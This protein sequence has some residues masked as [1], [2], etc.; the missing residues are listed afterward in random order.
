MLEREY[1]LEDIRKGLAVLQNYVQP[2]GKLN[3]TDTN[4][5]AEH[6]VAGLLN[7]I[8]GWS[9]V[10]TNQE[11]ANYPCIDLIDEGRGLGVQVT[12]ERGSAKLTETLEC[13]KKHGL[14][15]T[16]R[17]LIVFSLIAKQDRYT[18]N[19]GCPGIA[20]DW[21]KDVLDF[22][23]AIHAAIGIADLRQLHQVHLHVVDAMPS[24]FP[25][26]HAHIPPVHVPVTDRAIAWLAFSSRA[27][28]L[29]GRE[30][31][32]SRLLEFLNSPRRFSW[33][34][35]TGT[36]GSG[37]SRLALEL[38]RQA[39]PEWRAGF[40]SRTEKDFKWSQFSPSQKTLIV[41]DYVA[42]RAADVGEAVLALCRASSSFTK[43]VR[44]L[45]VE[46]DKSSWWTTFSREASLSESA[47]IA[48]CMHGEPLGLPRL[49]PKAILELAEDVVRAR[50]GKWN[51]VLAREFLLRFNHFDPYGRP[52]FAMIVADYL[53]AVESDAASPDLL[54][55]VL[56]R[57]AGRWRNLIQ[58]PDRLQR[59]ENLLFLATL[60]SGLLPK[61]NGFD[62]LAA[63]DAAGLLP[64]AELLDESLYND[65]AGAAGGSGSL[66]GL[67]PD[68]LGERFVLERVS[69]KGIAGLNAR[70]LLLAAWSFQPRDVGVVAARSAFDFHGHQELYKLF[71]LPVDSSESRT[72]WAEM[73]SDLIALTRGVEDRFVQQQFRKLISLADSHSHEREVQESA[74][75]A[76]Y[77]VGST[78]MFRE[79][80]RAIEWF[81]AAIARA[82]N[83][84]L[85]ARMAIHNRGILNLLQGEIDNAFDAFTLMIETRDA[86]DEMRA[87]AFNNR[88][89]VYA[90]R[91]EHDNAIRDRTEVLALQDTS[92]DRRFIALFR[93]SRS[94]SAIGNDR[95]ALDDLARILETWDITPDQNADTRLERAVIMRHLERWEEARADLKAVIDSSYLF[96][97]T[98]AMALVELAEVSRRTGEHPQ[99]VSLLN[100][101]KEDPEAREETLVD[102]MI[103]GALLLE[104]TGDKGGAS[105]I[106]REVLAEPSASDGQVRV[107]QRRL[108]AISP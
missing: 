14:S 85:I 26:R 27:T 71:D 87:C 99:A 52:L 21:R 31:E 17:Q 68:I 69:A 94:Y 32:C 98:R 104:D 72:H 51:A 28:R 83:D 20:F 34:L 95:A 10:S 70:R 2:G 1:L 80:A 37:K 3:L 22:N 11:S 13:L 16:I 48:A 18:V 62:Y 81:D 44:V 12:S 49:L 100:R 57:E 4:V 23:D 35:V 43:P 92:P 5:H 47:E 108:D 106:W 82:P 41:I 93:R 76:A 38:C 89:D 54:Q 65:M 40:L 8:Y 96:R 105:E 67:Q 86:T 58:E 19:V 74:A 78:Y 7:A 88:A 84:S 33:W 25:E 90:E 15:A 59:M 6:F 77:N 107:A 45:L 102:A 56:K 50:N 60:V 42:S 91:G 63:S 79:D 66:A 39:E 103:V 46:R 9:L 30:A 75:R 36:A 64:D 73:V 97:G 53:E 24:V 101:A 61:A 29:V 55:V